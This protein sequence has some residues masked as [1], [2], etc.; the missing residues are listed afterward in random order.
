MEDNELCNTL[1]HTA[2]HCN[3][4]QHPATHCNTLQHTATHCNTL[5]RQILG[6]EGNVL[7]NKC[8]DK[9]VAVVITCLKKKTFKITVTSCSIK[10]H[11]IGKSSCGLTLCPEEEQQLKNN[12]KVAVC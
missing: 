9:K 11:E 8:C 10:N 2:T 3:T 12:W 5:L 1:Q 7:R 6:M 4:L